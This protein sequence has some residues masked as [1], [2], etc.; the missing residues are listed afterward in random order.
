MWNLLDVEFIGRGIFC[1]EFI[2]PEIEMHGHETP[3]NFSLCQA[4]K[5][6]ENFCILIH[7]K[8]NEKK[9]FD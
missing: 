2:G 5:F 1:L 6:S 4:Q 8:L 3:A 9:D 7:S